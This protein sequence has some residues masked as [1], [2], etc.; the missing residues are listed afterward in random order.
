MRAL[1]LAARAC[2]PLAAGR[3]FSFA[4]DIESVLT[5]RGCNGSAC[6][7]GVKGQAGFRLS[8]DGPRESPRARATAYFLATSTREG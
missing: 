1:A 3:P 8:G 5:R 7:G 2:L 6:H 4:R